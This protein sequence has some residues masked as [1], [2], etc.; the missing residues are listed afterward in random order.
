M[1]AKQG[2]AD[3]FTELMQ[4]HMSDMV[5]VSTAILM[6]DED[7]ADTILDTEGN[8]ILTGDG[9]T[10]FGDW[11]IDNSRVFQNVINPEDVAEIRINVDG[12]IMSIDLKK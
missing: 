4:F 12:E 5:K 9:S 7:A 2:D 11:V 1:R 6:N 8:E 3:A 10:L